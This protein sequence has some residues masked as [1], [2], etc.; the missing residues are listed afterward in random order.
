MADKRI[1]QLN[2]HTSP[3]GSDILV[4]VNNNE[5]KK[6]TYA[7]LSSAIT[8]S[9]PNISALNIFTESIDTRVDNLESWSSSLDSTFATDLQVSIVSSSVAATIGIVSQNT[10]LVSTSSFNEYT[11]SISTASLVDRLDDLES[12]TG[13]YLTSLNGAIS[14]SSQLTSSYDSRYVLSGSIT[15]TTWD[16][17][18]GKPIGLVSQSTDISSLNSFTASYFTDSSSFDSRITTEKGR[19]DAILSA[20]TADKDSFAEIVSLINSVDLTNDTAFATYYTSSNA[21]ISSLE[22]VTSSYETK[23]NGIVS[24]SSQLTSSYDTRYTL[25]GSVVNGTTP[26]GTISGSAQ[27]SA[28]GFV[29]GSYTTTSSFNA[30]TASAQTI[31]TGSNSFNGTQTITGSLIITTG[32]F[33]GSQILANTSSL[34]LTSGSNL[35]VQNNGIVEI[36]GSLVISGSTNLNGGELIWKSSGMVAVGTF[37]TLDN[38][39]CTVTASGN[40]GLSIA[41][42]S[43]SFEADISGVYSVPGATGGGSTNNITYT[44]TASTSAFGW[45]F[46]A[47]GDT[48][49]YQMRDKTNNRFYRITLMIGVS[50]ISNF[51]SIERLY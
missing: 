32:S 38:L 33:I 22:S 20:S 37:V 36:T 46:A 23:G 7:D 28:F 3:S 26:A 5:T 19:I 44:T 41:A 45:N 10:G 11:A 30:F 27:I 35:Y 1:S 12:H 18:S 24:G 9:Q 6:I 25:S 34:Y 15:Q 51:I 42:V 49:I 50:Y 29:S 43:T 48:A 39:K 13:S 14:G 40:R 4:I 21:R 2:S 16:N 47:H 8:G 17:I 31:T